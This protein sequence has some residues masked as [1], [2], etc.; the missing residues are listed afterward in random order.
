MIEI[1]GSYGQ[2]G[3]CY[4]IDFHVSQPST[5]DDARNVPPGTI[6]CISFRAAFTL[7][8]LVNVEDMEKLDE[9]LSKFARLQTVHVKARSD[10]DTRKWAERLV[11]VKGM[12]L[13]F[14][15]TE[16]GMWMVERKRKLDIPLP[17]F[18]APPYQAAG[19]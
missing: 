3:F 4:A 16:D 13:I 2:H 5:K 17:I 6:Q 1:H 11:I 18:D 19:I 12:F 9:L 8:G 10:K 7:D 15:T 14:S